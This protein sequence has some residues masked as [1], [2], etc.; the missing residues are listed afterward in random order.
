[1]ADRGIGN[2]TIIGGSKDDILNGN[3][4]QDR[5]D[6]AAGD[7]VL[8]GG[9]DDDTLIGGAG[10]DTLI[11]GE[12]YDTASYATSTAGVFATLGSD[13]QGMSPV[14]LSVMSMTR[15]RPWKDHLMPTNS[16]A[17]KMITS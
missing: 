12:G 13:T 11:G 14:M 5:L 6:G 9:A 1:M 4:G 16:A 3:A 17:T 8:L 7:D 2:D 15:S 10:A